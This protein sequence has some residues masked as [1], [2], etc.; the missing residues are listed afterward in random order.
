MAKNRTRNIGLGVL[1]VIIIVVLGMVFLGVISTPI[2]QQGELTINLPS[3]PLQI[4][5]NSF[6]PITEPSGNVF[7]VGEINCKVKQT[8]LVY[9]NNGRLLETIE[10][11]GIQGS[12][13][14]QLAFVAG[15]DLEIAGYNV[16]PKVFC[17][18]QNNIP[19]EV[20]AKELQLNVK[21]ENPDTRSAC[22]DNNN[23]PNR[24]IVWSQ[25]ITGSKLLNFGSGQGEQTLA[26]FYIPMNQV[27]AP[28]PNNDFG[29]WMNF[30]LTGT[31]AVEYAGFAQEYVI[32]IYRADLETHDRI[33][34]RKFTPAPDPDTDGDK[35]IDSMDSCPLEPETWNG[36]MDSDGC[37]DVPQC[38]NGEQIV[39]DSSGNFVRCEPVDEDPPVTCESSNDQ[40]CSRDECLAM[41]GAW[42]G[43]GFDT[44]GN[45]IAPYCDL[46]TQPTSCPIGEKLVLGT[47]NVFRCE[48]DP[49]LQDT[50]GDGILNGIDACPNEAGSP[51][52]NGCPTSMIAMC[53]AGFTEII[54]AEFPSGLCVPDDEL[55]PPINGNGETTLQDKVI[56]EGDI[57]TVI[58]VTFEDGGTE[59]TFGS[60]KAGSSPT[61]TFE[62]VIGGLTPAQLTGGITGSD[63][64]IDNILYR[65]ILNLPNNNG[66]N[67]VR[68]QLTQQITVEESSVSIATGGQTGLSN[69]QIGSG[70]IIGI[71][72]LTFDGWVLGDGLIN[73][74]EIVTIGLEV[75]PDDQTRDADVFIDYS[76]EFGI[77]DGR[78]LETFIIDRS[79]ISFFDVL[80]SGSSAPDGTPNCELLGLLPVEDEFGN[81]FTCKEPDPD[82]PE[83][84]LCRTNEREFLCDQDYRDANCGGSTTCTEPDNDNDGVPNYRDSCIDLFGVQTNGCPED[85]VVPPPNGLPPTCPPLGFCHGDP[86]PVPPVDPV[87]SESNPDSCILPPELFLTIIIVVVV[88]AV[89]IGVGVAVA[90]RR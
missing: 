84:Q 43:Q 37:P 51:E 61:S 74:L 50:D 60:L 1:G 82:D 21:C 17:S 67:L 70:G 78:D 80:I 33:D 3:P 20:F 63:R 35:Y 39:T 18:Q 5:G 31:L 22:S 23:I 7:P 13:F 68:S 88:L 73:A 64:A 83:I 41:N 4:V 34:I 85:I 58:I 89:V 26:N 27:E 19:I 32:P 24:Q 57:V 12:P 15:R 45:V 40:I 76:G 28:F 14:A 8:T 65:V 79:R 47:G 81:V 71:G 10:S 16:L 66:I 52:N 49:D 30:E 44:L 75:I 77:T 48:E 87:C 56:D 42:I 38:P 25:G 6:I 29:M 86:P 72:Q 11:G 54:T 36:F 2:S 55:P 69:A 90:R 62:S 9:G 53:P 59:T 46:T